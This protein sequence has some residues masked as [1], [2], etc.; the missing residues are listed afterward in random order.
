MNQEPGKD[1]EILNFVRQK[2]GNF[3]V[4][5]KVEVNGN[6]ACELFKY[7]RVNSS[8]KGSSIGWNFGK[9]LIGREEKSVEYFGPT[10]MPLDIKD[11]IRKIL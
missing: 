10:V 5:S 11:K 1:E 3:P 7:L 4:F 2:G 6:N 9:F 8:L